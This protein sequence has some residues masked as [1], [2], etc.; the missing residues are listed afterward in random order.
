LFLNVSPSGRISGAGIAPRWTTASA[1]DHLVGLAEVGEVGEPAE[2]VRAAVVNEVDVEDI[3]AALA[4]V[5]N[6]P[7]ASLAAAAGKD[8][9]FH[10]RFLPPKSRMRHL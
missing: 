7:S 2:A 8:H 5:A 10:R 9:S 3:V 4:Q 1:R 6:D